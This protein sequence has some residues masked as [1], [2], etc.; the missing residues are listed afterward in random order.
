[1]VMYLSVCEARGKRR[2]LLACGRL[3]LEKEWRSESNERSN[4]FRVV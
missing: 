4:A 2:V 1:M 3:S